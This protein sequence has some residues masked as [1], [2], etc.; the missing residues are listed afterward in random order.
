MPYVIWYVKWKEDQVRQIKVS[1]LSRRQ[2]E[3]SNVWLSAFFGNEVMDD[4]YY[5]LQNH[6]NPEK[7][8]DWSDL[9][10]QWRTYTSFVLHPLQIIVDAK[11]LFI[12]LCNHWF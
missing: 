12:G 6:L 8:P 9:R 3:L 7:F 2:N 4:D 1:E 10:V 5:A 11:L